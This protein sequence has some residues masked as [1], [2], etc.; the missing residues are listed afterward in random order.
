[1]VSLLDPHPYPAFTPLPLQIA[2]VEL[3]G[4]IKASPSLSLPLPNYWK[5]VTSSPFHSL[6]SSYGL[7]SSIP[8]GCTWLASCPESETRSSPG[9]QEHAFTGSPSPFLRLAG[10]GYS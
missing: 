3:L 10:E 5:V 6:T 7:H 2:S 9:T 1:M 4:K 8:T